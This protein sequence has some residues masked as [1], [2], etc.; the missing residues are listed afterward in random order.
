M[1]TPACPGYVIPGRRQQG[2]QGAVHGAGDGQWI[3]A[4]INVNL[5]TNHHPSPAAL[6][7]TTR[8]C[9]HPA[10][11]PWSPSPRW[12]WPW[13]WSP[14][15]TAA[16]MPA[17]A[18]VTSATLPSHLLSGLAVS[19]IVELKYFWFSLKYFNGYILIYFSENSLELTISNITSRCV[20]KVNEHL[21]RTTVLCSMS[22]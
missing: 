2:R 6:P 4:P 1:A 22:D 8:H 16:P 14:A 7:V 10:Q 19:V 13:G 17:L 3:I 11:T 18:P 15:A 12:G 21:A 5:S 20:W 9:P